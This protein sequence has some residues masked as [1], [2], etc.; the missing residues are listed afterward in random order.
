LV[1]VRVPA[2]GKICIFSDQRVHII[3]D[4]QAIITPVAA[5]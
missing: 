1:A 4:L 5:A 2:D 3:A